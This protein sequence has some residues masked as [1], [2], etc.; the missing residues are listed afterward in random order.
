MALIE[1]LQ[2]YL[3]TICGDVIE[4]ELTRE[5]FQHIVTRALQEYNAWMGDEYEM[6][7]TISGTFTL[8][9][10]KKVGYQFPQ[11]YPIIAAA[12]PVY[13]GFN[14]FSDMQFAAS[15]Y[16]AKIGLLSVPSTGLYIIKVVGALTLERANQTEHP[17][18]YE[19]LEAYYKI[20]VG[21]RRKRFQ[22]VDFQLQ[23][24]GADMY[25]EGQTMLDALRER[26]QDN[27]PFWN[28]LTVR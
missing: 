15:T 3:L 9:E 16:D 27:E 13:A 28:V 1:E 12:T 6:T 20:I 10:S 24:D 18:F 26:L 19:C 23:S 5:E 7:V 2:P 8:T 14:W 25:N 22:M 21:S 11:P 4:D 17:L